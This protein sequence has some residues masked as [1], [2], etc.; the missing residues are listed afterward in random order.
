MLAL[1]APTPRPY[2]FVQGSETPQIAVFGRRVI[3]RVGPIPPKKSA[4]TQFRMGARPNRW[5][6]ADRR[7]KYEATAE[8]YPAGAAV[9]IRNS[10]PVSYT[11]QGSPVG[12]GGNIWGEQPDS[13]TYITVVTLKL[14]GRRCQFSRERAAA[15]EIPQ[16]PVRIAWPMA[17]SPYPSG[18]ARTAAEAR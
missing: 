10:Q 16:I 15:S 14:R 13:Q 5:E 2:Y 3:R 1:T 6:T 18:A 12:F 8:T 17:V 11:W 4:Y 7:R 9:R